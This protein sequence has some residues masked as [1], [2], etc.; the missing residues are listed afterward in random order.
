MSDMPKEI[1]AGD[2]QGYNMWR[3]SDGVVVL[4]NEAK[5]IRADL[6]GLQN[7]YDYSVYAEGDLPDRFIAVFSDGSGCDIFYRQKNGLWCSSDFVEV[8]EDWFADAGY[9]WFIALPDIFKM[10]GE[11]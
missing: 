11:G 3:E 1:W 10:W 2:S 9:L 6:V 4:D 5:Y 8:G 7:F